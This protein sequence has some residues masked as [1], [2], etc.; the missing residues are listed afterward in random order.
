MSYGKPEVVSEDKQV[1]R[2]VSGAF[3]GT[4]SIERH[5]DATRKFEVSILC[6]PDRP[7]SGINSY[8]TVGL[9]RTALE[10]LPNHTPV[11]LEIVA[12]F[13]SDK[14]GFRE[15]LASAAFRI[16]RTRR[17]AAAG[18]VFADYVREWYPKS[19]VPHLFFTVPSTWEE[20][21]LDDMTM[22]NLE[23]QFL[24]ILPI[25]QGEYEFLM[26]HGE[27]ALEMRLIGAAVDFYDLKRKSA[28]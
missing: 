9:W 28:V 18:H 14:E 24:Q 17:H 13:P 11:R 16:M 7:I 23:L 25:T 12:A 20:D 22:G 26:E 10:A 6:A 19:T 4:V 21:A 15:I 3:G 27:D 1:V 2:K 5:L 8:S